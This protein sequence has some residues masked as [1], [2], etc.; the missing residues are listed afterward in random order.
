LVVPLLKKLRL[1]SDQFYALQ[2]TAFEWSD[3]V[4]KTAA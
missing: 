3:K 1:S 2:L 4:S